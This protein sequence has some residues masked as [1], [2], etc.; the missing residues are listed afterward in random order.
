MI[1]EQYLRS[2]LRDVYDAETPLNIIELGIVETIAI[3]EDHDAPGAGIPGVRKRFRANISITPI[4]PDSEATPMLIER[5]KNR[6]AGL[7]ALSETVVITLDSPR[8]TPQ[9]ITPAGYAQ[10]EA[11]RIQKNLIQIKIP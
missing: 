2:A 3:A 4:N 1:D 9:R 5:I 6:L 11:Q 7:E 10:L 8:W